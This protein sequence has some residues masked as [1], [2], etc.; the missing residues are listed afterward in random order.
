[1]QTPVYYYSVEISHLSGIA[2]GLTN[3][4]GNKTVL[5]F[6]GFYVFPS[7]STHKCHAHASLNHAGFVLLAELTHTT[8]RDFIF[9]FSLLTK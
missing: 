8:S 1:M 7:H 6:V 9:F 5:I 2:F 4:G 3:L